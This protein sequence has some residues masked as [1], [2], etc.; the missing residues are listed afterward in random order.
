[1][2]FDPNLE[3]V[4]RLVDNEAKTVSEDRGNTQ[5]GKIVVQIPKPFNDKKQTKFNKVSF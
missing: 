4:K 5:I 1:M 2:F 3:Q